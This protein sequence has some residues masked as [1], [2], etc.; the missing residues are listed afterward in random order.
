I[1]ELFDPKAEFFIEDRMKPHWSQAGAIV[2][3]TFRTSDSIP[4]Q[5]LDRWEHEKK[6]WILRAI[7]RVFKEDRDLMGLNLHALHWSTILPLLP[8]CERQQFS[9]VFNAQHE[10]K[11]DDCL[12]ACLLK[13]PEI[14][15]IVAD[16][17]MYFDRERYCMGDFVIMPNHVHLLVSFGTPEAMRAQFASWL[18]YTARRINEIT[19]S[20]GHFWQQ[21]PFDHLVRSVD[22][23]DYLRM[24]IE[25]NPQKAGLRPGEYFYRRYPS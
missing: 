11:L 18:R 2:F 17:L 20:S 6:D 24:Y 13:Q 25:D 5:V 15:G 16:S 21:E 12:G 3:V 7:S 19:N 1:G 23:Y 10:S 14:S 22:Q 4:V 9:R 8:N